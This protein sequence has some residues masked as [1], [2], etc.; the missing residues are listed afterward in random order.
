MIDYMPEWDLSTIP[1]PVWASEHGRRQRAKATPYKVLKPCRNC[2]IELTAVER[3]R[4]CP[5][6]GVSQWIPKQ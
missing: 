4:K 1:S 5:H 3:R 2:G 6:C